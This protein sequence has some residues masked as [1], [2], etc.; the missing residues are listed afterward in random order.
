MSKEEVA[1]K[2][3]KSVTFPLQQFQGIKTVTSL[4]HVLCKWV[5]IRQ[6][7]CSKYCIDQTRPFIEKI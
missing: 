3:T 7:Y 6:Q 1:F 2:T 4:L 5:Y